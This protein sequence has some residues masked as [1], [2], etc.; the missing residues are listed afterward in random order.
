VSR[1]PHKR[2]PVGSGTSTSPE[3][4]RRKFVLALCVTL[5]FG[6]GYLCGQFSKPR[7]IISFRAHPPIPQTGYVERL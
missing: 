1:G 3:V 5:A 6:I 2:E 4:A 7:V